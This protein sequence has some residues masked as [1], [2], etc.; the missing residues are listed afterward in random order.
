MENKF[1]LGPLRQNQPYD[2]IGLRLLISKL[3]D[4]IFL[5]FQA[6][7]VVLCYVSSQKVIHLVYIDKK[8][9]EI[10]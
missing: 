10:F 5:L 2:T 3:L 6:Q 9:S 7:S 8:S 4:N 1:S